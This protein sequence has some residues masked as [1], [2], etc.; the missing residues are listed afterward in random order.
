MAAFDEIFDQDAAIDELRRAWTTGKLPHAFIFTGPP[1]VGKKLT[2]NALATLFL[3]EHPAGDASACGRCESCRGMAVGTHPDYHV[4]HR[5]LVRLLPDKSD[6]KAR[7]LATSVILEFLIVPAGRTAA[8]GRGKVFLVEEADLMNRDAQNRLLKTLE[9]PVGPT[10]IILLTDQPE[11]LLPTVR[12]RSRI[13]RFAPLPEARI[14]K[15]LQARGAS[16]ED[17][18]DAARFAEGS[19]GLAAQWLDEGVIAAARAFLAQFEA[20]PRG[21]GELSDQLMAY[22]K[23]T[24]ERRQE[25]D[26]DVALQQA[27]RDALNT[28]LRIAANDY[29]RQLRDADPATAEAL[30]AKIE[31]A[32]ATERYLEANVTPLLAVEHLVTTWSAASNAGV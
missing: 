10:L 22:A 19:L 14:R 23:A 5:L 27:T 12:S 9:E 17:A 1:G 29:R 28:L 2:A 31:A 21:A 13:V 15:E 30:C 26:P 25:A 4:V 6:H 11:Y 24:A 7:D 3:C 8:R 16:V 20:L 32:L 18:A